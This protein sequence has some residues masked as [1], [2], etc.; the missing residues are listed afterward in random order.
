MRLVDRLKRNQK[1]DLPRLAGGAPEPGET[2]EA[3]IPYMSERTGKDVGRWVA[4]WR[5]MPDEQY[6]ALARAL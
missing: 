1:D 6:K 5:E 3:G 4:A 2:L